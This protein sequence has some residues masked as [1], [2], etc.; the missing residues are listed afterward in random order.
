MKFSITS[1]IP[2]AQY[3]NVQ[4][5]VEVEADTYE[6][7]LAMVQPQV[8]ALW[9][10]YSPGTL[11]VSS[12]NRKLLKTFV[13]GEVYYDEVAHVYTNEAGEVYLSGSQYANSFKKP[14][15]KERIAKLMADKVKDCDPADII[16]MWEL[17]AETSRDFGNAIHKSLQLYEQYRGLAESLDKVTHQHDHP[18]IKKAVESFMNAHKEKALSEVLV[19]DHTAKRA[20]QIDRLVIL[21]DKHCRVEDYK[22]NADIKKELETYWKQLEFYGD[23]L[24]ADGWKVDSPIIHH[25]DGEWHT[26]S[27]ETK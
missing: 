15:D 24:K 22:T 16:K 2:V 23:I 4:P 25:Y 11:K 7:A 26:Y 8:H 17:K 3:A 18:V 6:E 19:V 20:G 1:V 13:G 10:Q 5:S 9:E 27:K 12:G 14:F 21:G